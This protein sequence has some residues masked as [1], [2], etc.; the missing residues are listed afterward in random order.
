ML[1]KRA[2]NHLVNLAVQLRETSQQRV[3]VSR[4]D[5]VVIGLLIIDIARFCY[6]LSTAPACI[7]SDANAASGS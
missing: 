1:K 7:A 3:P 6:V 4:Y 5:C 2:H